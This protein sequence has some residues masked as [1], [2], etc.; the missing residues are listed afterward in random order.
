MRRGVLIFALAL[1]GC[2]HTQE[3]PLAPNVVRLD[4]QAQG[5]LFVRRTAA[6]TMRA[7]AE[8][9]L[10]RGYSHF[11]FEDAQMANGQRFG[12]VYSS[13]SAS[14][15]GAMTLSGNT[16]YGHSSGFANGFSTPVYIPT[17]EIAVTVIMFHDDDPGAK[18]AFDARSVLD[19]YKD[20]ITGG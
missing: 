2:I 16:L 4:T 14:S 9:T 8:A 5:G 15:S 19:Q 20:Q 11:R 7:A 6:Q 13:A 12:G 3:M 1:A 17:S 10:K 18:S